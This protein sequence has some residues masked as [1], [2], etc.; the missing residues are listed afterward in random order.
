MFLALT[1]PLALAND[2]PL[3]TQRFEVD[4]AGPLADVVLVQTFV[5]DRDE[6][7]EA[8]YVFPLPEDAAVDGM[9]MR[10]A[11]R[12]IVGLVKERGEARADYER[13]KEEG[14]SAALTEQERPN[15]FTQR[16]A[17]LPPGERIEVELHLVVPLERVDG[18]WQLDLPLVAPPRFVPG[19][20]EDA[21]AVTPP[22]S[23]DDTGLRVDVEVAL[24]TGMPLARIESP[25][26]PE[27][28]VLVDETGAA[29]LA[30]DLPATR[31][32]SLRWVVD[33]PEPRA[34]AMVS[35]EHLLL[36]FEPPEAPA[37]EDVVPREIVWV[38]DT[39]C[40]MSG[41]PL[42][43]AKRA[44]ESAFAGMDAR[45]S[46]LVLDFNDTVS[47]LAPAPI[48]A[49]PD[50]VAKGWAYVDAFEGHGG[51]D[52]LS[53]ILAA[54][55]LPRDPARER[56]VCF[57]TDGYIGNETD[58]LAAVEDELGDARLFSFGL[59]SSVNRYLLEEMAA[60]GRGKVS[61]TGL[62]EDP[63][64][65]VDA[66]LDTV[67]QPVLADIAV[68]WGD[69][70]VEEVYPERTPDLFAG[71]PMRRM[72][73][74]TKAGTTPIVVTGRLGDGAF[75]QEVAV[76]A[77]GD[78]ET[79]ALA[80]TWARA[81]VAD[82]EREQLWGEVAEVKTEIL[83]TALKHR[84]MTRYTSFVAV[85]RRVRNTTGD[86]R[87]VDV[88]ANTPDGVAYDAVVS[89]EWMPPGDPLLTV[90]AP[91]DARAVVAVFPWGETVSLRWDALRGRW[92]HR[93]LV[94]RDVPDGALRIPVFVMEADGDVVRRERTVT[95]DGAAPE[96]DVV[97]EVLDGFTRVTVH[98]EEPL[99]SLQVQ[100]VGEPALRVR[101]ELVGEEDAWAHTVELPGMWGEVEVVAKDRAMNTLRVLGEVT[102]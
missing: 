51:T 88:P 58:I 2:L 80:S 38:V 15:L 23:R 3:K 5:N 65:T 76:E 79:H 36:T 24:E 1:V 20:V 102:E 101:R 4:V 18:V 45:D 85:D 13:A 94:P 56:Y 60:L 81:K 30:E 63:G 19:H 47:T 34:A 28:K 57:L 66:F 11:D 7:L 6:W 43:L 40:S 91:A 48:P 83:A 10:V 29:V 26:H 87:T 35:G 55:R 50:N 72:A 31:D 46:F 92:Y 49:S 41:E 99:R 22:L 42:D 77:V 89:R 90:D 44:M 21:A 8:T 100:P 37:R 74:V 71:Q 16:V 25:S 68:E 82:L 70:E 96:L 64:A 12:E 73:R 17:N 67:A 53:G 78:A 33:A 59:G 27:T 9:T 32:F 62:E 97:V 95:I 75:R 14:R 54:L 86:V 84:L 39:S 61:Y 98:A 69:W 93:F 52:M